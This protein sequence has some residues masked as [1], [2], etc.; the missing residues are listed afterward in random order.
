MG[1]T[2]PLAE[3]EDRLFGVSLLNDWSARDLQTWEYQPLGPFLAKNFATSISPWI[4]TRE[5]LEPFRVPAFRRPEGDPAP[6]PY[7][8]DPADRTR[9]GFG[10]ILEVSLSSTRMRTEG[11]PPHRLSRSDFRQMYWTLA[12]MVTHHA[13]NGC[14]LRPGDL[15]GSGT[16]SGPGK[17]ERGCLLEL[18]WRGQQPL[19]LPSGESRTF[20]ENGDEVIMTGW[21]EAE[22][23]TRIGLGECRGI[24]QG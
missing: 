18:S 22:G 12:Q 7:L 6:L 13:S 16:V 15:L 14:N 9:G 4:V 1:S 10:I 20:L 8:D 21:C 2:V 24:V 5:A 3:A 17:D 23:A 19:T 11:L